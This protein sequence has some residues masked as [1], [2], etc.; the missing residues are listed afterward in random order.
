MLASYGLTTLPGYSVNITYLQYAYG[1]IN[2]NAQQYASYAM[3][4][5]A[6]QYASY[7]MN[8]Q[9]QQQKSPPQPCPPMPKLPTGISSN[10][11][12]K[13]IDDAHDFYNQVFA[14]SP[15][16]AIN[17]LMGYFISKFYS[18]G[19]WDYKSYYKPGTQDYRYALAF[20]NYNFG[21]VLQS[22]GFSYSFTQSAAGMAQIA[23]CAGGGDCGTGMPFVIY[24]YG[25]QANDAA[26]IR[27]GYDDQKARSKGCRP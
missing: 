17:A 12:Q 5:Q 13:N 26:T 14:A 23:I 27:K 19:E 22:F 4:Y 10:Q 15:E 9:A 3:H 7:A 8:Y 21:A 6:Q 2:F 16:T 20:G 1:Q 11:I 25:D 18:G 24:P